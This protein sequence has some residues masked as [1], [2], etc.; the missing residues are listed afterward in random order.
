MKV[1]KGILLGA[2]AL[3]LAFFVVVGL[4]HL[5]RLGGAGD[6]AVTMID[7]RFSLVDHT[8]RRVTER[9]FRGKYL[10]IYFGYTHCPELCPTSLQVMS[11]ALERLGG[12][13]DDVIPLFITI[14][15]ERDTVARMAEYVGHFDRRTIGLTGD[16]QELASV[17]K[18]FRI[19]SSRVTNGEAID[20]DHSTSVF[21][22]GRDGRF[23]STFTY[24][25]D[26]ST[27]ARAIR[28]AMTPSGENRQTRFAQLVST[29]Y[30]RP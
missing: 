14:D 19:Q 24:G 28:V 21:F 8:G 6:R 23:I 2:L 22:I 29:T 10:L 1:D 13:A 4:A 3:L 20:F 9:D 12:H 27:M 5:G 26:G 17:S 15:P 25:V 7:T 11:D 18:A 30:A 16:A